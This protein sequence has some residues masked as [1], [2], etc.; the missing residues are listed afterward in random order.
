MMIFAVSVIILNTIVSI[1]STISSLT[2]EIISIAIYLV[3]TFV[4]FFVWKPNTA[5]GLD[6]RDCVLDFDR[7]AGLCLAQT[8]RLA[9]GQ[10]FRARLN[11]CRKTSDLF[12]A[13]RCFVINFFVHCQRWGLFTFMA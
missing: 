6:H 9:E 5:H 13:F 4:V 10:V 8:L 2:I 7:S 12:T 1:G 11:G 3:Y